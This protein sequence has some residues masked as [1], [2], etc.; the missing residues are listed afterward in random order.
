M[1]VRELNGCTRAGR[2]ISDVSGV[3]QL[4][5]QNCFMNYNFILHCERKVRVVTKSYS[6]SCNH[7]ITFLGQL[8]YAGI[9]VCMYAL[10]Q[11]NVLVQQ[12]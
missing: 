1:A 12:I 2:S 11:V 5:Y 10:D 7:A 6:V 3:S 4:E 9:H 8:V